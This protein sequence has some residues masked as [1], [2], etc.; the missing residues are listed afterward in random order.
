MPGYHR[1]LVLMC[2]EAIELLIGLTNVE[3]LDFLVLACSEKP[4][5]INWVPAYLVNLIVVSRYCMYSLSAGSWIP[6]LDKIIF[7][8]CE[9]KTLLGMPVAAFDV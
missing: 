4:I 9:D 6:N 5:T 3:D 2:L 7:A 8:S 1:D